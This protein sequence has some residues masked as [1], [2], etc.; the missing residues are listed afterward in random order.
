MLAT[1][2]P[3]QI[4]HAKDVVLSPGTFAEKRAMAWATLMATHGHRV[5][6][7]RIT[8]MQRAQKVTTEIVAQINAADAAISAAMAQPMGA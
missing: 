2:T 5:N 4:A 8:Q 7:I 3:A 1:P 6:Q